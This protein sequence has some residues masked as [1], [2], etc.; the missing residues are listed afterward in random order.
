MKIGRIGIWSFIDL[1]PATQAREIA[2][3]IESLGFGALWI[4]EALGREAFTH[5]ALLLG[6]TRRLVVAT[7]IANIWGRDA[8]TMAA[9]HKT[10]AEAFP[11]RFLLGIGVSHAPLVR[12]LRGHDYEKPY[13]FMRNYLD[14]MDRAPFIAA[15]PTT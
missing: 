3:E 5:A 11:D 9:A 2:A 6:G 4:P 7:G 12:G 14:A 15:A 8:M 13:T 10:L 1:V